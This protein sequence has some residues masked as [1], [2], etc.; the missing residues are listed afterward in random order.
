MR[1]MVSNEKNGCDSLG[2]VLGVTVSQ[3]RC[4]EFPN[5]WKQ[6]RLLA[7]F[8]MKKQKSSIKKLLTESLKHSN[9][10]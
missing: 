8:Y 3:V 10:I 7:Y 2:K 5:D 9:T 4:S 1:G 6:F